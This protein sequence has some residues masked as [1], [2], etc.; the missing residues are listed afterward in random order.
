MTKPQLEDF[1]KPILTAALVPTAKQVP[2][3]PSGLL[4]C[5]NPG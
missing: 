3:M 5:A 2:V 4:S 1:L